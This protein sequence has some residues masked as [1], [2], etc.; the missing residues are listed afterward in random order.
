[1]LFWATYKRTKSSLF[2][3]CL[4]LKEKLKLSKLWFILINN[5]NCG[6]ER[7]VKIIYWNWSLIENL[8]NDGCLGF[9]FSCLHEEFIGEIY[10]VCYWVFQRRILRTW[11]DFWVQGHTHSYSICCFILP[12]FIFLYI[13]SRRGIRMKLFFSSWGIFQF[14]RQ[15]YIDD[16]KCNDMWPLYTII[17]F[18]ENNENNTVGVYKAMTTSNYLHY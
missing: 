15:V 1:M 8:Y 13:I 5:S 12:L 16:W 2:T 10:A 17:L 9:I 11:K 4:N 3:I 18:N 6:R 7:L 14:L